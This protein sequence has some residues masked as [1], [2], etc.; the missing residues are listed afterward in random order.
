MSVAINGTGS[1]TGIDQGFNVTTG[2]VGIGTDNP[3]LTAHIYS[4]AAT[5]VALIESTQNFATL[6]FKSAL[7]SSGPTIG[8][9]GAG[10]L[11][12]DQKDT[13]KYISFAIGSERLRID[14]SGNLLLK[15]GE[16]DIQGGNKTVKT[17]AG[18]LQVGTSGSHYLSLITAGLQRLNITS[19]G[20]DHGVMVQP[21][22]N[23][24][25]Y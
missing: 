2:S 1:I 3:G 21:P 5:D 22:L 7:N 19:A 10:G 13:S 20:Q 25:Y 14:S 6:R 17:S 16:I 9:D 12:L 23:K 15:T 11:Q 8:I 4:T 24:K 18:F